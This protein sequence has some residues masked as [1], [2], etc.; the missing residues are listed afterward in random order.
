MFNSKLEEISIAKI[1]YD[2]SL[3]SLTNL[4]NNVILLIFNYF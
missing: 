2:S 4:Q 3:N 1:Q